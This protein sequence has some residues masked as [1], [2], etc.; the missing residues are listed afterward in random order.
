MSLDHTRI[1][2]LLAVRSLGALDG[3]EVDE[4]VTEMA[5]H[6]PACEECR[7]LEDGFA[8]VAGRLAFALDPTPVD[9]AMADRILAMARPA[10]TVPEPPAAPIPTPPATPT[11]PPPASDVD[12]LAGRREGRT[13]GRT[14]TALIGVAAA[15]A[16]L[17]AI[18]VAVRPG[19]TVEVRAAEP[20]QRIVRFEGEGAVGRLAMAYTPGQTGVIFWGSDLPDPGPDRVYEIWMIGDDGPVAG[21]C[22]VPVQGRIALYVEADVGTTDLM[23]VTVEPA[24]CPSAPTAEAP[25]LTAPL[26]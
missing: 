4:L 20:S 17:V 15:V 2:E 22:V 6:G 11:P 18:V 12:E 19:G 24:E 14:W 25:V 23:A 16:L 21:G 7:A 1:E 3:P 5:D 10:A 26:A 8:E 9:P 13:R